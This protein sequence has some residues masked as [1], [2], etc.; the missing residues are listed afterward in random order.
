MQRLSNLAQAHGAG[1]WW[2]WDLNPGSL[3]L[4]LVPPASY[5]LLGNKY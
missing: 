3:G 1:R 2:S 4:E 5:S